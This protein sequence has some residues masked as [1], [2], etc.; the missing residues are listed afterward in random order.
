MAVSVQGGGS[1]MSEQGAHPGDARGGSD[2]L[3]QNLIEVARQRDHAYRQLLEREAG[4]VERQSRFFTSS[5]F[6]F[7]VYPALILHAAEQRS[8]VP[9]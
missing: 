3:Q 4:K 8:H 6:S 9:T 5:R 1:P 2:A 7:P